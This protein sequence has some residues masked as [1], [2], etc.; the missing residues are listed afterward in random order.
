MW[1]PLGVDEDAKW[2]TWNGLKAIFLSP[3]SRPARKIFSCLQ[4]TVLL[5]RHSEGVRPDD[6]EN[7]LCAE[8]S[9]S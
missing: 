4:V 2:I 7:E 3:K 9:M 6:Q 1:P 5:F 8:R